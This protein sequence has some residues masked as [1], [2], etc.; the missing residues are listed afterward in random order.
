MGAKQFWT[1]RRLRFRRGP[2]ARQGLTR[3]AGIL[4][5]DCAAAVKGAR[6]QQE[7]AFHVTC[8]ST[9]DY[10]PG[11]ANQRCQVV[12]F[13]AAVEARPAADQVVER[14]GVGEPQMPDPPVAS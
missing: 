5:G 13:S 2:P 1:R 3:Q 8:M 11:E 12:T 14:I 7:F 4:S 9:R 10:G 6:A